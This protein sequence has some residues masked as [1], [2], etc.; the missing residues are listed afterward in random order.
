MAR[1][2]IYVISTEE[3]SGKSAITIALASIFKEKGLSVG[4]LKPIGI[5]SSITPG[6]E[7]Y[8]EDVEIMKT[9]LRLDYAE[10]VICPILLKSDEFLEDFIGGDTGLFMERIKEA[11]KKISEKSDV[12]LLESPNNF[13]VGS[14]IGCPAPRIAKELGADLILIEIAEND[15]AI[16]SVLQSRDICEKWG[17]N[18]LGVIFNRVPEDRIERFG[19]IIKPFVEKHGINVLGIIPEE[20]E[21]KAPTVRE[22]C[23]F[24]G[25]R[26]LAG[27]D[28][29]DNIVE[30]IL[31]GAMTPESAAKY[32]RRALNEV[33]ITGGD[34]T[35]IILTALEI[36]VSAIILTGNLYP[37]VKV[38]PKADQLR[39]PL[40]L[41]PYD[42]YTTLQYIQRVIGRIK[43]KD[44]RRINAAI[45]LVKKHVNLEKIINERL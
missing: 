31:V 18:L 40:L 39:I 33:V 9:V 42:T 12:V 32:F 28:G 34:R 16:D 7:L 38:F 2:A 25:G 13:M 30:E 35:D 17:A 27:K 43:P 3:L 14:F 15:F 41:V 26:I 44:A 21:L 24:I 4:Y 8:D 45:N 11:Y 37:S 5:S 20:K 6:R 23:E 36:G 1:K 29:L 22:I 19:G 10:D